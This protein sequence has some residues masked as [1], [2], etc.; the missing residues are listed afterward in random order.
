MYNSK[1]TIDS[2]KFWAYH[3]LWHFVPP[4]VLFLSIAYLHP[5]RYFFEL[6]LDEGGNLMKSML[7]VRGYTLYNEIWSDQPPLFTYL[8]AILFKITDFNVNYAR[9]LVLA[10]SCV[11]VWAFIQTLRRIWGD[12]HAAAGTIL[13]ILMPLYV[14]LSVSA[15]IGLPAISLA[16]VSLLMLVSWHWNNKYIWLL[17]SA[18]A[19]SLSIF[20]KLFTGFLAPIFVGGLLIDQF[21][22]FRRTNDIQWIKIFWPAL[23]WSVTFAGFSIL[24]GVMFV[25]IEHFSDIVSPHLAA[26][27]ISVYQELSDRLSINRHLTAS[28]ELLLLALIGSIS[29]LQSKRWLALYLI[30]WIIVAYILLSF[31]TPVWPHQQLLV[32]IPAAALAGGAIGDS[33]NKIRLSNRVDYI[34]SP[35]RLL[36][37]TPMLLFVIFLLLRTPKFRDEFNPDAFISSDLRRVTSSEFSFL[38]RLRKYANKTN[39]VLTDLPMYAF[40]VGLPV[41]PELAVVSHKRVSTGNL[42]DDQL[43]EITKK[44]Q[45]EQILIGRFQLPVFEEYVKEH[46]IERHKIN[47]LKLYVRSD[48]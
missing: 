12:M 11:L 1:I 3:L 36:Y 20:F 4:L 32:T 21:L 43:I 48:I 18:L 5:Y 17:I 40:R 8:L 39:W 42:T 47:N 38:K 35:T 6:D 2:I 9:I 22:Q 37:F 25:G 31:N 23:L 34:R 28:W 41:P 44:Y 15:M 10:F 27:S 24:I 14:R 7:L 19:L 33:I 46:Y 26:G 29:A 13:L 16:M 30:A 45:P